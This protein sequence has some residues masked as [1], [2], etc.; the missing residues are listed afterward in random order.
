M[1]RSLVHSHFDI[2]IRVNYRPDLF[3]DEAIENPHWDGEN[4]VV[5]CGEFSLPGK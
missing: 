5:N 3:L 2:R 4:T 1:G